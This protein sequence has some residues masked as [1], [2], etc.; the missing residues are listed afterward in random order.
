MLYI[1][2]EIHNGHPEY[3]GNIALPLKCISAKS[4]HQKTKNNNI[5]PNIS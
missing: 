2:I 1:R 5:Y 4:Y 3:S